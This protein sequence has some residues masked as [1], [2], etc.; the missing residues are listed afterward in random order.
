MNELLPFTVL[1]FIYNNIEQIFSYTVNHFTLVITVVI[2]SL[3]IWISVGILI[4]R[5]D[6][7]SSPIIGLSN[8]LFC[9]PSISFFGI[10]IAIPQLGLGRKSAVL[11]LLIYSMMPLVRNVYR[12]I[13]SVDRSILEAGKGMG[14]TNSQILFQI[15]LPIA[16][17]IIFAG[18]RVTVVMVTG[19]AT[20]A[21]FIG[22]RNLGR[23]IHH[24]LTRSNDDMI[25]AGA[26]IV[27]IISILLDYGFGLLEKKF[28]SP[29]L[30]QKNT[31]NERGGSV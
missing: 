23:L 20:M 4:S 16:W 1:K 18:I 25:I 19:I 21:T 17:P 7:L 10:F 24:G 9:I 28:T 2:L 31:G 26:V 30:L 3:I 5:F 14:M 12:G 11:A 8:I 13:K 27:S 22:E 6:R 29:G 15:Q